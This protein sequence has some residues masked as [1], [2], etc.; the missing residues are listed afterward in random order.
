MQFIPE[1]FIHP[2]L[3][4]ELALAPARQMRHGLEARRRMSPASWWTLL[5]QGL[6]QIRAEGGGGAARSSS[7]EQRRTAP[8]SGGVARGLFCVPAVAP[9]A[10]P[11]RITARF[12]FCV[13]GPAFLRRQ[14]GCNSEDLFWFHEVESTPGCTALRRTALYILDGGNLREKNQ[15]ERD[16]EGT[17]EF[18]VF[19]SS[20]SEG[21]L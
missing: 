4:I 10:A 6:A 13:L 2:L 11:A 14:R 17:C 15:L 1:S 19:S 21:Q 12:C 20:H 18:M 16:T 3:L 5:I 8:F 7:A 9:D